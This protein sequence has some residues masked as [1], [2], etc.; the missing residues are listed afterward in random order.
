MTL[1]AAQ[2]NES[3]RNLMGVNLSSKEGS[4]RWLATDGHRLAQMLLPVES[5]TMGDVEDVIIPRKALNEV[6]RS[7]DLFGEQVQVSF[8]ERVMQFSGESIVYKASLI[9][10]NLP[11]CDPIIAKDKPLVANVDR[12]RLMNSLRIVSS[13]SAEKLKPVKITLGPNRML[14]ESEKTDYGEVSDELEATYEGEDFQ[15]GFNS[16]Y[17]L[18]VL[19]VMEAEKVQMEFKNPMSPTVLRESGKNEFLSVI[20]PLRIEW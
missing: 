1:F 16:R 14:L 19:S 12:E 11:K 13:I 4:T 17:L 7:A 6:R 15:I 3:R 20:M 2:T 18:D 5:L 8:D 9:V 10:G